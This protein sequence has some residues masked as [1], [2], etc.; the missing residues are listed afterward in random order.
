[1]DIPVR[2]TLIS[3]L[4][5]AAWLA[6]AGS[7]HAT[8]IDWV[9]IG[10]P[11]NA[12]DTATGYGA[13]QYNYS[14]ARFEVSNAQYANFLTS[15]AS[16]ADPN[17]LFSSSMTNSSNG[18]INK[19]RN[20][21]RGVDYY[22]P[23][24][25][26]GDKPVN[27][28]T[29]YDGLR[30]ANWLHNGSPIGLQ[31]GASTENGAYLLTGMNEATER[32]SDAKYFLPSED[33]WYK[34]AYYDATS[35]SYST[36]PTGSD[37]SPICE[38]PSGSPN[39][40]NCDFVVKALTDVG[41]YTNASSSFGTFDQG[42]NVAEW[43]QTALGSARIVRGGSFLDPSSTDYLAATNRVGRLPEFSLASVGDRKSVV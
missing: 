34:A 30:Y 3:F 2:S 33:E 13:V 14:L 5:C 29:Y 32:L 22:L 6:I 25:G 15:V 17:S 24:A 20:K 40:A 36:Y 31:D 26:A 8:S 9:E 18:G 21:V 41:A 27:Y 10:A 39:A 12:A 1:M 11:A 4:V 38:F 19:F 37:A 35:M 28:V 43:T 7:T 42:G 16:I 23:K